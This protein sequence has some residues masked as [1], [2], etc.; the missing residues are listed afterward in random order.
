MFE[1]AGKNRNQNLRYKWDS[2]LFIDCIQTM[3]LV[4]VILMGTQEKRRAY[5]CMFSGRK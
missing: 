3:K 2:Y 1:S 5:D 4:Y